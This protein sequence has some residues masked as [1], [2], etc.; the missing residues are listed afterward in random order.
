MGPFLFLRKKYMLK[1]SEKEALVSEMSN[2]AKS[3]KSTVFVD[4]RGLNVSDT[5]ILKKKLR[6]AGGTFRVVKKTLLERIGEMA[7]IVIDRKALDGQIAVIFS[8]QDEVSA[9]KAV[10]DFSKTNKNIRILGGVL[11]NKMILAES[12]EMLAKMPGKQ[13]MLATLVGTVQA[14]IAGFVRT[15]S[16]NL[17]GLVTVLKAIEEKK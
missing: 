6:D 16:G 17:R 13:E 7:G 3:S 11:E 5:R 10:Y 4:Y 12:V 8:Q 2:Q 15:L 14:P 1:R 9:V